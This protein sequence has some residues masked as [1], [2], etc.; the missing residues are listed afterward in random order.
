MKLL[1]VVLVTSLVGATAAG[2]WALARPHPPPRAKPSLPQVRRALVPE[3]SPVELA[4]PEATAGRIRFAAEPGETVTGIAVAVFFRENDDGSFAPQGVEVHE[5]QFGAELR[6]TD[7]VTQA[8]AAG[9]RVLR[10]VL[11][12]EKDGVRESRGGWARCEGAD[13]ASGNL[14]VRAPRRTTTQVRVKTAAGD[15]VV[16]ALVTID[17][18][19][20][21]AGPMSQP[22]L[23]DDAGRATV[24]ALQMQ[25]ALSP[26]VAEFRH[27]NRTQRVLARPKPVEH[28]FT[29]GIACMNGGALVPVPAI[30]VEG[31]GH[32]CSILMTPSR[33]QCASRMSA[34]R[35][36]TPN[37]YSGI[38]S[39]CRWP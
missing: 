35:S 16:G 32:V 21:G 14:L 19:P 28:V 5:R 30:D 9:T 36:W 17:P 26:D 8:R 29:V 3:W 2:T 11:W 31:I 12:I 6:L 23:T 33:F 39:R 7:W 27:F 18:A 4:A 1:D 37:H 22:A 25:D 34:S 20:L 15:P 13:L 38:L 24:S 10:Y